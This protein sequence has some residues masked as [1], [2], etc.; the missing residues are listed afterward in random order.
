MRSHFAFALAVVALFGCG[1]PSREAARDATA[2]R[3]CSRYQACGAIAAGKTYATLDECQVKQ[4]A[5]WE[6]A[7]PAA[8]CDGKINAAN[9]D[10]CGKAIDIVDC[11]NLLDLLNVAA[12]CD[13]SKVCATDAAVDGGP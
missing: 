13:K 10:T 8:S 5:T 4:K 6:S 3:A 2:T 12:K 9:Y 11:N 1:A 7:W